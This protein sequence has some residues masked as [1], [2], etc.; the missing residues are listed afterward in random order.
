MTYFKTA[1]VF[2]GLL[3][4]HLFLTPWLMIG[5]Y[6]LL[7]VLLAVNKGLLRRPLLIVLLSELALGVLFWLFDWKSQV[8]VLSDNMH[9]AS[10]ALVGIT[11]VV[12]MITAFLVTGSCYYVA[13]LLRHYTRKE[14]I[15]EAG[16]EMVNGPDVLKKSY[17]GT[18]QPE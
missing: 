16:K 8:S 7:G 9:V 6:C 12:N 14:A 3:V 5:I 11:V 15:V 2:T 1:A 17:S 13:R 10:I 4:S 18:L